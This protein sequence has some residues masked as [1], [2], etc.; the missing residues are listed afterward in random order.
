MLTIYL[1]AVAFATLS[2]AVTTPA[3]P[4]E[5]AVTGLETSRDRWP[6]HFKELYDEYADET[7]TSKEFSA[8]VSPHLPYVALIGDSLSTDF[9]L[10][11]VERS[12]IK[13]LTAQ[14]HN[15]F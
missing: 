1:R 13:I 5:E 3:F 14:G 2:L 12:A 4:A 6:T 11:T 7:L 8:E 10:S 9:H 15:C